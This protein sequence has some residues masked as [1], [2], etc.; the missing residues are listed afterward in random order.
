[1]GTIFALLTSGMVYMSDRNIDDTQRT[2]KNSETFSA[3]GRSIPAGLT[4][5]DVCSKWTWAVRDADLV[6]VHTPKHACPAS[7][8]R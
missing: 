8:A 5:A 4:A 1:M 6:R 3:A 2:G 7:P